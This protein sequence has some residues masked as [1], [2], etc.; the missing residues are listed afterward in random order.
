MASPGGEAAPELI[1]ELER[2]PY[3]FSFFQALRLLEQASPDSARIGQLGPV[4]RES[5]RLRPSSSMAFQAADITAIEKRGES[6]DRWQLTTTVLGLYGANSPLPA[7]YTEAILRAELTE[8]DDPARVFLDLINHRV[9]SLLYAAWSK[10]RW[11][12][13]FEP[14]AVDKSSQRFFGLLGLATEGLREAIGVPAGRLLRYAGT[15]SMRPRG[16]AAVAGAVSD[17]FD[18]VPVRIEQCLLRWVRID[19]ADRNRAGLL[20]SSLGTDLTIGELVPDRMGKC[21]AVV[22]PLDFARF[23]LFL[24]EGP[25]SGDLA[26]LVAL[27]LQ[28][29]IEWD[30]RLVLRGPEVPWCRLSGDGSAVR[31]GWTSWLRSEPESRDRG[32][33]FYAPK[34]ARTSMAW[35]T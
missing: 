30:M 32:E 29:P 24:P 21:R 1:R 15:F 19:E 31:L 4:A 11:E 23:E 20:N 28:D 3:G 16:A 2:E 33:L 27:L 7:F 34:L 8:D 10:Y 35:T 22:G 6:P 26:E 9:L 5:V 14:G 18:G 25:N 17:F 13:T 12:F